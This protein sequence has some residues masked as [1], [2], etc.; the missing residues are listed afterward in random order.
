MNCKGFCRKG[1]WPNLKALYRH[2]PGGTDEN[3]EK[4]R[5]A[6]PVARAEIWSRGLRIRSRS[7]NHSNTTFG[8][9]VGYFINPEGSLPCSWQSGTGH[10]PKPVAFARGLRAHGTNP[11]QEKT[12]ANP[13]DCSE[14]LW[15]VVN[16]YQTTRRIIPQDSHLHT[17]SHVVTVPYSSTTTTGK[18]EINNQVTHYK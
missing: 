15:N 14:H 7:I 3:H 18:H 13:R 6:Y 8:L 11:P 9:T 1:S 10:Y 5:S 16:L 4:P 12:S 2:S 17:E